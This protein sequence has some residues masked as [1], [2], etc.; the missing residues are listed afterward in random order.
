MI[1]LKEL[2]DARNNEKVKKEKI[3]VTLPEKPFKEEKFIQFHKRL[4]KFH[5]FF[6]K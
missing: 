5:L 2:A 4:M 3:D 1:K 6:L